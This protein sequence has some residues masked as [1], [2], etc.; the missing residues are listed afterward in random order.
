[1]P[2]IF[3]FG[4]MRLGDMMNRMYVSRGGVDPIVADLRSVCSYLLFV[5]S[6]GYNFPTFPRD[7]AV[8]F[9]L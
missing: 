7:S 3:G 6:Y 1:M 9:C 8:E 2:M 4:D 5:D